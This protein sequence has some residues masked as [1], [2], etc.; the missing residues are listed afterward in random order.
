M[1]EIPMSNPP[2]QVEK[3][4]DLENLGSVGFLRILKTITKEGPLHIS[5]LG[6]QG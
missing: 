1:S 5:G 2:R 6:R 3:T 4:I